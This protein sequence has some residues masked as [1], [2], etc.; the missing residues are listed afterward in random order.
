MTVIRNAA[1]EPEIMDLAML[2]QAMGAI[3]SLFMSLFG[4]FGGSSMALVSSGAKQISKE[5]STYVWNMVENL[6]IAV[7]MPM[8]KIYIINDPVMNAFATGRDPK[9]ASIA[10][11][12]GIINGLENEELEGVIAHELSHVR[13]YDTRLMTVVVV[14]VGV[15]ALFGDWFF[16]ARLFGMG[17]RRGNNRESGQI[18]LILMLVGIVFVVLS[19]II[20]QL[21]KLA[22]SR[23]REYLADASAVL[24]TRYADGLAGALQKIGAQSGKLQ[25]ANHATAHL[26][27][28]NPFGKQNRSNLWSTHPPI[29]DRIAALRKMSGTPENS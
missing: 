7:G 3:I 25:H 1:V 16:R 8:P 12:T 10:L 17:D 22:I 21:I 19:P 2:L 9:H 5:D 15:I 27:F 13:N 11:T 24:M 14:L 6:C 28:S 26:Y 29:Q 20:A 4:Y 18:Q 23:R